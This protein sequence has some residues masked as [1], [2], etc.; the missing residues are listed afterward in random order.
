LFKVG[1][2]MKKHEWRETLED[3]GTRLLRASHHAGVWKLQVKLKA[4][5]FWTTLDPIPLPELHALRD[6]L[7]RKYQRRRAKHEDVEWADEQIK[8]AQE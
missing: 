1:T 2:T 3:G 8:N 7:W 4:D 5:E 6:V